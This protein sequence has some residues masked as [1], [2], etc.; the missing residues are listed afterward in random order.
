[1]YR[2]IHPAALRTRVKKKVGLAYTI[3]V[4]LKDKN[5]HFLGGF[6]GQLLLL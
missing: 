3:Y 4:Q 2:A 1:M 6:T 5:R